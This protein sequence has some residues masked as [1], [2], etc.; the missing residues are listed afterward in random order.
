M[1]LSI[2]SKSEE[3]ID[4]HFNESY[5]EMKSWNHVPEEKYMRSTNHSTVDNVELY[6]SKRQL[7]TK[8][9]I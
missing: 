6:Y 4:F 9:R 8:G 2:E 1:L 7:Q 5:V 3:Y